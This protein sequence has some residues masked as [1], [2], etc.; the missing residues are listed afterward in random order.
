M[1]SGPGAIQVWSLGKKS[2]LKFYTWKLSANWWYWKSWAWTRNHW[3]EG[4]AP[5]TWK[6]Q[7]DEDEAARETGKERPARWKRTEGVICTSER[8]TLRGEWSTVQTEAD[9]PSTMETGNRSWDT[10][11]Q[12][13]LTTMTQSCWSDGN[14]KAEPECVLKEKS[15]MFKYIF[16]NQENQRK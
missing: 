9:R 1:P 3:D 6:V 5:A 7:G 13:L 8:S 4:G 11:T 2:V 16:F 15:F 14:R 10:A 12:K